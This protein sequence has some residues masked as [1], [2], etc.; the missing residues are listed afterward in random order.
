[1]SSHPKH[2]VTDHEILDLL[3]RR[4]SPRAF[5]PDREVS[6]ADLRTMFEAA[7]WAP[8]SYNEQP[9]RF[10]VADRRRTPEVFA[11]ILDSLEPYNLT[12]AGQ[13][14]LLVLVSVATQLQR[15][16]GPNRNASYDAG[17][18]VALLSVQATAIGVSVRQMEGFDRERARQAC[19]I[20][21]DHEPV[22]V[23]AIGYPGDPESLTTERHRLAERQPRSRQPAGE[24][25]FDGVWGTRFV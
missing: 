15:T 23:M 10:V 22:V 24:F 6:P 5:E 17:Q 8:S 19:R 20:P 21:E 18:A 9:W 1:M 11:A 4:W 2:A 12:W 13:A 16:G 25:V 14:P 3:S 7:R